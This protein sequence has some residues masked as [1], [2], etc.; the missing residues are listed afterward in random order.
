[1]IRS[2]KRERERGIA[3]LAI[4]I[5]CSILATVVVSGILMD[6]AIE[7]GRRNTE[8][9]LDWAEQTAIQSASPVRRAIDT[10]IY[11]K[12]QK[13][14]SSHLAA[15]AKA[16]SSSSTYYCQDFI[17]GEKPM[18]LQYS[19]CD[20]V[21]LLDNLKGAENKTIDELSV[22]KPEGLSSKELSDL[23]K[24][25]E[26]QFIK[27][28]SENRY[29]YTLKGVFV[30]EEVLREP[31]F[32]EANLPWEVR[33]DRYRW[34]VQAKIETQT[35]DNV[36]YE[37]T[38]HYDVVTTVTTHNQTVQCEGGDPA[39]SENFGFDNTQ[40]KYIMYCPNGKP[41]SECAIPVTCYAETNIDN[42][43]T[44][45]CITKIGNEEVDTCELQSR[46]SVGCS[47]SGM[48]NCD[49]GKKIFGGIRYKNTYSSTGC[50]SAS[51]GTLS[52]GY[53]WSTAIR[54]VG[55]GT[56]YD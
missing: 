38:V 31:P 54:I 48:F 24:T 47:G 14:L 55:I 35:Y 50:S 7:L 3:V 36:R 34:L 2:K 19:I 1:M 41:L 45:N 10:A 40:Q 15:Q 18:T 27:R 28:V 43:Y 30:G 53:T 4:V 20:P 5:L 13:E 21:S 6:T 44:N 25:S 22:L 33:I 12:I 17:D 16:K 56:G 29:K 42:C 9:A 8:F 46:L 37:L 32:E 26:W 11:T 23:M 39:L 52:N 49:I 51:A